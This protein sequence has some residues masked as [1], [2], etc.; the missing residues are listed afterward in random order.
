MYEGN[1]SW[2][3]HRFNLFEHF[4]LKCLEGQT[5]KDFWVFLLTDPNT[6][7]KYERKIKEYENY[8][9]I[10][11]IK[12]NLY[13]DSDF[14]EENNANKNDFKNLILSTYKNIRKNNSNEI[15]TSRLDNDDLVGTH[16]NYIVKQAL[17]DYKRISL[18]STLIYNFITNEMKLMRFH[19]GSFV[20][21]KSTLDNWDNP[22]EYSHHDI[23]NSVPVI[24]D[25]PI[26]GIGV[27]DKNITNH[28]W[29]EAGRPVKFQPE[30][31]NQL[32]NIK[33]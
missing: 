9:F 33:I 13:N 17:T 24:T 22:R 29:W 8:P 19:K 31:F 18:E 20:S 5:D 21:I 32:F 15:I 23:P 27:H 25:N 28:R 1:P 3:D 11:V 7:K 26:V 4:T 10:K 14:L 12:T 6:P 30:D 2:L 16:Y